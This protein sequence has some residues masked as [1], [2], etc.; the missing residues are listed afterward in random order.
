MCLLSSDI[1]TC[2]ILTPLHGPRSLTWS[3]VDL[4]TLFCQRPHIIFPYNVIQYLRLG[5][6]FSPFRPYRKVLQNLNCNLFYTLKKN[7]L[8]LQNPYKVQRCIQRVWI[9]IITFVFFRDV[10]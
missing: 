7:Q 10:V 9:L 8:P 1:S 3:P 5:S 4:T 2:L 6:D